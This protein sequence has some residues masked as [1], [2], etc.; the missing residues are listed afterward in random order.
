MTIIKKLLLTITFAIF[1]T[2]VSA[3]DFYKG[4]KALHSGDLV[5]ALKEWIPLAEQGDVQTQNSLGEI[6]LNGTFGAS[7]DYV[8]ALKWFRLSAKLGNEYA[9]SV[10][11]SMYE[12]GKGVLKDYT[13]GHMWYNIASA[14]GHYYSSNDR[15]ALEADMTLEDISKA[16]A[17]ARKCMN[18]DYKK[19]G[20]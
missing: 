11:G 6:Y 15:D 9:Q 14:N 1:S 13:V 2:N 12:H 20:Y 3:Q 10:L 18:S 4:S 7:K 17:M 16:T 19:C 8:E 5:T